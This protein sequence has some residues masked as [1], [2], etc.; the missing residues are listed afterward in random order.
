MI[1]KRLTSK[2]FTQHSL[3]K[4]TT[5]MASTYMGKIQAKDIPWL[6]GGLIAPRQTSSKTSEQSSR[7]TGRSSA[8]Q[9]PM[10]PA[11]DAVEKQALELA[12]TLAEGVHA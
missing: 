12:M 10:Q 9:D 5:D 4:R 7:D 2:A 6:K 11:A 1:T 3:K 8:P